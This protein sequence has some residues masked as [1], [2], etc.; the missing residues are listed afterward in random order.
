MNYAI[1]YMFKQN[2]LCCFWDTKLIKIVTR[3]LTRYWGLY[4][5]TAGTCIIAV[6]ITPVIVLL[7]N[8]RGVTWYIAKRVEWLAPSQYL[9]VLA[10][11]LIVRQCGDWCLGSVAWHVATQDRVVVLRHSRR[12][13]WSRVGV[14]ENRVCDILLQ[15]YQAVTNTLR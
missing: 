12:S 10:V 6:Y 14:A 13:G 3:K 8:R 9:S 5:Y 15:R 11:E 2:S 4:T 1:L 7:L